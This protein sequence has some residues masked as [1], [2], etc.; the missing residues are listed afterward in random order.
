MQRYL[1]GTDIGGTFTDVVIFDFVSK[2][3]KVLKVPSN[4]ASPEDAVIEAL[5]ESG[6]S[7][8][9]VALLNHATTVATNALLTKTG[10]PK[11]ALIT[12]K[13]FRDVLEI[14]RQKRPE[15]YNLF[16]R[17][18]EPLVP[19]RLRFEVKGRILADGK[20][21]EDLDERE[22]KRLRER[23]L[24]N[25][26]EAAAISLINSYVNPE[27]EIKV[28]ESISGCCRYIFA[29]SEV[30]PEYREYERTST[31]VVNAVLAPIVSSYLER[32]SSKVKGLGYEKSIYIM[33]S[34]GGLNTVDYA[35]R[36]PISVIESGPAAGVLAASFLAKEIGLEK[37][38]TFDM[39]GTTAKA[40]SIING[41][42]DVA[43]EFEAAG[44]T[45][46]GRSIKGSGYPVRFPFIDLAEVSAGGGTIAWV[47]EAGELRVGPKSA[48]ADPG[49]AAYGRGG[50]DP[51]VTDANIVLGRLNQQYL[52]GGRMK[53]YP[54]LAFDALKRLGEQIGLD[55]TEAAEG[56]V[57]LINSSMAKAISIVSVER[58][59]DPREF[60]LIAFGGAG[61][62]H[63]C[64]LA[65]EM[66][67]KEIVVP[68]HPGLFSAYGLLAVDVVRSYKAPVFDRDLREVLGKLE[69]TAREELGREGF[70][71][72][73]ISFMVD[74]R[75]VG[76]S[77]E[78][79]VD[80]EEGSDLKERFRE[81]YKRVYGFYSDDPV[82]IVSARATAVAEVPKISLKKKQISRGQP[83][84]AFERKAYISGKF[85]VAPVYLR[86]SLS[87]GS[88]GNGP[89]II[90]EY[91]ST[92]V[93]NEGWTWEVDEYSNIII[94]R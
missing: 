35:S 13:G 31:T 25:R 74:M 60:A 69:R 40:S 85:V 12:N 89:A 27:H 62:L 81:E 37:A 70:K 4:P 52:L 17:K 21:K 9:E 58:G 68:E 5:K 43:Y 45:H 32:F 7:M 38:I 28:K 20:V 11:A 51:T 19:R 14:G 71:D 57:R 39:G 23:L 24:K 88:F 59:R 79:T 22:L 16:F 80:Y 36:M 84:R 56:V 30:D 65:E 41:R 86:E 63:A 33:S 94:R 93:V 78:L 26:V 54:E 75:Y 83:V 42:P 34:N 92:T 67:I 1:I 66:G 90:E 2:S 15:I 10:L 49:P 72:V 6:I 29:S 87:P 48:G 55:P 76:Q 77:Y 50:R 46:S 18:P 64:D 82:E 53:V 47:D 3:V 44:K 91:D 8:S 61:P 73:K